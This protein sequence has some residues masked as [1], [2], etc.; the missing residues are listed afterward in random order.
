MVDIRW[1]SGG[2]G[3]MQRSGVVVWSALASSFVMVCVCVVC[4]GSTPGDD[5]GGRQV[6]PIIS[7][8]IF[9]IRLTI[10]RMLEEGWN[11]GGLSAPRVRLPSSPTICHTCRLVLVYRQAQAQS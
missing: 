7:V 1:P 3:C 10:V 5:T 11:G 8:S 6:E 9:L 2:G 4:G